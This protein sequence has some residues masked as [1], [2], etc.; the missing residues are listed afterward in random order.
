MANLPEYADSM[1]M[2]WQGTLQAE[3]SA[4]TPEVTSCPVSL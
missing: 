1:V 2:Y 4:H 3:Y